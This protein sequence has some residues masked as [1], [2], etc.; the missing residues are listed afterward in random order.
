M[1]PAVVIDVSHML[2]KA[3]GGK[4]PLITPEI[5]Q[6]NEAKLGEIKA[7][8]VVLFYSGYDDAYYKPFPEGNRLA[9]DPLV[10][11]NVPGWPAPTPE[12]VNI[13]GRQGRDPSGD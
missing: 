1:G 13:P 12:A 6:A 11:G 9:W 4:S 2:D 7:G 3:E 10:T 5:I 8:D